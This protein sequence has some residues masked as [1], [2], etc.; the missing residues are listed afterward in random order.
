MSSTTI[1]EI[2]KDIS[3]EQGWNT[4]AQLELAL[5]FIEENNLE[6]SFEDFLIVAKDAENEEIYGND[7]SDD[8][9]WDEDD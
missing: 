1:K 3:A 8:E 7:S 6:D 2:L 9:S 5:N 4:K